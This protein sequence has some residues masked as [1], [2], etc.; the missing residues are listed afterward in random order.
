M[1][2]VLAVI[3]DTFSEN[4][5]AFRLR[6]QNL[7]G[8]ATFARGSGMGTILTGEPLVRLCISDAGGQEGDSGTTDRSFTASL[9]IASLT[10]ALTTLFSGGTWQ[11]AEEV[12]TTQRV[13]FRQPRFAA[14]GGG[15]AIAVW[16]SAGAVESAIY[17]LAGTWVPQS[18]VA[19]DGGFFLNVDGNESGD[20]V[21]AL[22]SSGNNL[23]PSDIFRNF[24]DGATGAWQAVDGTHRTC[25][26]QCRA[27]AGSHRL[28]RRRACIAR[29]DG[30]G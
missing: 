6:L 2:L 16:D 11:S 23:D 9:D 26:F 15:Q 21:V 10:P 28:S 14:P 29:L 25:V 12:G 4:D 8:D 18:V 30:S 27:Y 19:Q 1:N 5:E 20:A 24:Y 13:L 3:G 7:S 22:E 17:T